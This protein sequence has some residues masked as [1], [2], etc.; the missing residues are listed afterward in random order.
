MEQQAKNGL[1][2][3]WHPCIYNFKKK[4]GLN[5]VAYNLSPYV[6]IAGDSSDVIYF[7]TIDNPRSLNYRGNGEAI[8]AE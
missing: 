5:D 8:H 7:I 3:N 1:K 6:M 2:W 4:I